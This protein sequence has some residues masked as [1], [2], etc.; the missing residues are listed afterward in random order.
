M[1]IG[2]SF[3][4]AFS[5]KPV[6]PKPVDPKPV[7]P[8]PVDPKPVDPVDPNAKPIDPKP[9]DPIDPNAKPI[10][11]A[12]PVDPKPVDPEPAVNEIND[13][14][15]LKYFKEKRGKE[16]A[17]LDD[18]FKDPETAAD[19]FEGL[20]EEALQFL[21]YNK[22]TNREYDQ[23]KELNR[24][25][26]KT[27]P[28]ELAREK[29]IAMSDGYLDSSNVD[30]YLEDE[31]K[32]DVSDFERL[33]PIEKMKLKNY[34]ADYLK[35]QKELQEKYKKPA[36][37]KGDVEMVT[38]ENGEQMSKVKYDKLYDQQK[39]YQQSIQ[40]SS[41]KIKVSAYDIKIDDNG[42]EKVMNVGYEYTKEEV[43][44]MASS[45]L[46]IDGFYQKAF[47]GDKGLDY[48]K[49]QEGLHWANPAKRE[50]AITAIVHKALAQ[51]AEDFSAI[52]HNAA[53]KV[54]SIPGS[55]NSGSKDSIMNW[56]AATRQKKGKGLGGLTPEQF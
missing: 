26:S 29:A 55:G 12:D 36:E 43:R 50:K 51:Q 39:V 28:A 19:P 10:D 47:G 37:R 34:G 6:D 35:S 48:G 7:D 11:P 52:E 9:V 45:A 18:F 1:A 25:Y 4:N 8:K 44:D 14:D 13:E 40:D 31:L 5:D 15:V 22:E 24:D 30:D 33:S 41:D 2:K 49:L 20:S 16:F 53:P 54:K 23:F 38:L 42:T 46:D 56:R 27:N 21:K 17:S 32:L 3:L